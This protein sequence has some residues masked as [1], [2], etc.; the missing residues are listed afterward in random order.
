MKQ[1][2]FTLVY[3]FYPDSEGIKIKK[4]HYHEYYDFQINRIK[5]KPYV[6][7]RQQKSKECNE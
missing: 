5:K 7:M 1:I 3:H 6:F 2:I 4:E